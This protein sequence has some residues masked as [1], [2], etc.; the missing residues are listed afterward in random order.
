MSQQTV[1]KKSQIIYLFMILINTIPLADICKVVIDFPPGVATV[2]SIQVCQASVVSHTVSVDQ[3][4]KVMMY[5][6]D[7]YFLKM[8]RDMPIIQ[9]T[10]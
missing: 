9:H 6:N 8:Y 2:F 1:M 3:V 5:R 7:A 4:E 10:G